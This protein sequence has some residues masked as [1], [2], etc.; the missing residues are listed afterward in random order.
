MPSL[1]HPPFL[2][3]TS[4]HKPA[5]ILTGTVLLAGHLSRCAR[6][7]HKHTVY[8][9]FLHKHLPAKRV[10][11]VSDPT[12]SLRNGDV[13]EFSNGWRTGARVRHVVERIVAPFV[14]PVEER[15]KV[16]SRVERE[17]WVGRRWEEKMRNRGR[18]GEEVRLGKRKG[19]VME[20]LRLMEE[21]KERERERKKEGEGMRVAEGAE[22]DVDKA[23]GEIV[24]IG[25][26]EEK[27][28]DVRL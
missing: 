8:N 21:E 16:M 2:S 4:A 14:T 28:K 10:Y 9:A 27:M 26:V 20:R 15:P 22:E 6:V 18:A 25:D 19:R 3:Q 24:A 11:L 13:I 1:P 7:L 5:K 17:E 23:I 12:S